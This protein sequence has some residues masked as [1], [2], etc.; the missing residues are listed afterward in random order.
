MTINNYAKMRR[1][2]AKAKAYLKERGWKVWL[3]HHTRFQKDIWGLFDG[4][5]VREP[6]YISCPVRDSRMAFLQIKSG[7][8]PSTTK[9]RLFKKA[10]PFVDIILLAWVGEKQGWKEKVI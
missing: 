10:Y 8:L 2:H 3:I 1:T 6:K 7:S 4:I 5:A 9:Y